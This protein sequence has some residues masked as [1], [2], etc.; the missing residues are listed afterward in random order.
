MKNNIKNQKKLAE[1]QRI[2]ASVYQLPAKHV[3]QLMTDLRYVGIAY[4]G[5]GDHKVVAKKLG[6]KYLGRRKKIFDALI[7][8]TDFSNITKVLVEGNEQPDPA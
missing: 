8:N 5:G 1:A 3:Q 4:E 2:L 7:E 6:Q